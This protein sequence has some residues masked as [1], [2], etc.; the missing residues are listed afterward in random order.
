M[1]LSKVHEDDRLVEGPHL[2]F[3]KSLN[4][5]SIVGIIL[6][7]QISASRDQQVINSLIVDLHIGNPDFVVVSWII[8]SQGEDVP[9]STRKYSWLVWG[10]QHGIGLTTGCLAIH[11]D[12]SIVA[13]HGSFSD[14]SGNHMINLRSR[15]LRAIHIV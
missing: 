3:L 11:E 10:P 14:G 8:L 4:H 13:I 15:D 6:D 9:N 1:L 2:L 7:F 12:S 5:D